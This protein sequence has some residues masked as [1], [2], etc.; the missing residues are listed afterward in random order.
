MIETTDNTDQIQHPTPRLYPIKIDDSGKEK[1]TN[2]IIIGTPVTGLVR[3]EWVGARY[4]QIIPCNWSHVQVN[5]YINS[6][7]PLRYQ[8]ADAQNLIVMF[9]VQNDYE[10]LLLW[11]HDV[12]PPD[13]TCIRL[14]NYML[15]CKVPIVSGLYYTRTRPSEPLVYRGRGNSYF[16]DWQMGDLVWCDGVPTG[17]LL[18]HMSIIK[19]MW[20]DAPEYYI[21]R[22]N[23]KVLCR[24]VFDTPRLLWG[25][26][27][28]EQT[29]SIQG[30]SDLD[31]CSRVIKGGYMAKAGWQEYADKEYPFLVDTHIMCKHI[32]P[33]GQQFP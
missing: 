13:D 8:V 26:P 30:T 4:G 33:D 9:A 7:Y 18:V 32:N 19:A 5:E 11:E 21:N 24:R 17:M 10:W 2:R 14:N 29:N 20:Q 1:F 15:D 12:L 25:D 6:Y 31:W 28:E 16:A 27:Q 22:S 23:G 3:I